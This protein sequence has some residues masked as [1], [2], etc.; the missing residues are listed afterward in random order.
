MTPAQVETMRE[1]LRASRVLSLALIVEEA[2]VNGLLPFAVTPDFRALVVHA[3]RLAR[4]TKG[5]HD[6]APFDA[7]L[8][9]PVVGEIDALQVKRVTLRGVVRVPDH[10]TPAYEALRAVYL[11]K[12]PEA[13]PITALG[14]FAFYVL[15]IEGGRLVTGFGAAANV[16]QETLETLQAT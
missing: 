9:E 15:L 14:D 11:M 13:E 7:L 2:P 5:L 4:H 3:S 16:T 6:G 1:L 8:H 10:G 12:F